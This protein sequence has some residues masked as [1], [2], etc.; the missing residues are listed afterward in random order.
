MSGWAVITK[1]L[2]AA[3]GGPLM[4]RDFDA[5]YMGD[6]GSALA[7]A[8]ELGLIRRPGKRVVYELTPLGRRYLAG[9]ATVVGGDRSGP[10][11][12]VPCVP[13]D[14]PADLMLEILRKVGRKDREPVTYEL[15]RA[16]S[17]ELVRMVRASA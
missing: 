12:I 3:G 17:T 14:V 1:A 11:R 6:P 9:M 16:Y 10:M 13:E 5:G 4:R 8:M 15:L 7:R 2:A